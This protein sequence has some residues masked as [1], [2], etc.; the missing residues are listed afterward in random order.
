VV[1]VERLGEVLGQ[2]DDVLGGAVANAEP[3]STWAG[4]DADTPL[5]VLLDPALSDTDKLVYGFLNR[6]RKITR[7]AEPFASEDYM[8]AH[9]RKSLRTM[10]RSVNSLRRRGWIVVVP[11]AKGRFN[12]YLLADL[13]PPAAWPSVMA[14]E[15]AL[16]RWHISLD[17]TKMASHDRPKMAGRTTTVRERSTRDMVREPSRTVFSNLP[18]I[19]IQRLR[20]FQKIPR[21]K[22][23]AYLDAFKK[24]VQLVNDKTQLEELLMLAGTWASTSAALCKSFSLVRVRQAAQHIPLD[25]NNIG[26]WLRTALEKGYKFPG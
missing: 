21:R 15:L 18:Y 20:D 12:R 14:G 19:E 10:R 3:H 25:C 7:G 1:P 9:L 2:S 16:R 5:R 24:A 13:V 22:R 4:G 17:R 8:A 26:A 11:R 6:M 23:A